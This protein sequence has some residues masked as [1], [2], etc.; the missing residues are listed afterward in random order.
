[1]NSAMPG[2]RNQLPTL[3]INDTAVV[4][5][6]SSR[7]NGDDSEEND[8]ATKNPNNEIRTSDSNA[9]YV[10]SPIKNHHG[11]D[12]SVSKELMLDREGAKVSVVEDH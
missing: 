12:S 9:E 7:S 3:H 6:V 2:N 10:S 5:D 1:M 4:N 11:G 8:K